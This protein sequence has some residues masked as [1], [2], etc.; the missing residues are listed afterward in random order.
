MLTLAELVHAPTV[1]LAAMHVH[2]VWIP[3]ALRGTASTAQPALHV[4]AALNA[5]LMWQLLDRQ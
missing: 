1:A 5:E 4:V 3:G 2:G